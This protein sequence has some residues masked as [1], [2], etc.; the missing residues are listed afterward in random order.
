MKN[1]IVL[2]SKIDVYVS[3]L[4]RRWNL[5]TASTLKL[6]HIGDVLSTLKNSWNQ[7]EILTLKNNLKT[8]LKR[9][10]NIVDL[11]TLIIQPEFN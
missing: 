2:V 9:R 6:G 3:T 11:S 8:T 4:K 5:V 7:V 1:G 10:W